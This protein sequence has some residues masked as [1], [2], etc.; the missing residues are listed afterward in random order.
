MKSH[1]QVCVVLVLFQI[2]IRIVISD[3]KFPS[4]VRNLWWGFC[5]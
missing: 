5:P 2:V 4:G 3:S 1:L